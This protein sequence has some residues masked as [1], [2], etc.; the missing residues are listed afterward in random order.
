MSTVLQSELV[1][2][3]SQIAMIYTLLVSGVFHRSGPF[4]TS[5]A[6]VHKSSPPVMAPLGATHGATS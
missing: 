4:A 2:L 1:T 5:G 6:L 3:L